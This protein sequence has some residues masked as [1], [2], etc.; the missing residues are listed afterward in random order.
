M[1]SDADTESDVLRPWRRRQLALEFAT[2]MARE[3]EGDWADDVRKGDGNEHGSIEGRGKALLKK[4]LK[5]N[6]VKGAPVFVVEGAGKGGL[7]YQ[8]LGTDGFPDAAVL[9]PFRCAIEFDRQSTKGWSQFKDA[10]LKA[11]AHSM[12]GAYDATLFVYTLKRKEAWSG[13]YLEDYG[14]GRPPPDVAVAPTQTLLS[15]L[16]ELGVVWAFVP[17]AE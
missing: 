2:R 1:A 3:C 8:L 11:A 13:N 10:L 17:P 4:F 15:R 7:S 16:T 14:E 6:K 5:E 9:S 12:S